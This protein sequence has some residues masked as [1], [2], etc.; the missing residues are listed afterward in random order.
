MKRPSSRRPGGFTLVELMVASGIGLVVAAI[1]FS[2]VIGAQRCFSAASASAMAKCEQSRF[3]DF[4][5]LDLRRALSV[6]PGTD[7]VTIMTLT[8]PDYY[9]TTGQPRTPTIVKYVATYGDPTKPVTIIYT[10]SG[11]SVFRK[12]GAAAPVEIAAGVDSF[13]VSL[14]DLGKVV[15]TQVT[16]T[17]QF[18]QTPTAATRAATTLY[19]SILLRNKRTPSS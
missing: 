15:K 18:R 17:P 11:S 19:S 16:F 1:L 8:I 2:G 4:M 3:S 5:S 7:G 12:V 13:Q 14:Q 6:T 9:D 10:K